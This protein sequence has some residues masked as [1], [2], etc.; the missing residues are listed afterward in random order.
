M[1]KT[2]SNRHEV[3]RF[4]RFNRK[5]Y[6]LF[7]SIGREVLIGTL[8][9]TTLTFAKAEGIST[10]PIRH[11]S[12]QG[13]SNKEVLLDEVS[14]TGSRVPMTALQSARIVSVITR[15]DIARANAES[16]NDLLKIAT[17]V[18][19][20]QRG[21]FGVQT[22]ISIDG[23]TFDQITILL[24]GVNISNPQ[25]GHLAA[26][27]PV[28]LKDIERIEV[29]EGASARV[30]GCSAFS[31]AI[32]IITRSD[33]ESNVR[34]GAE[35]GLFGSFGTSAGFNLA[36]GA[37]RNSISGGYQQSDG[38]TDNSDFKRRR[39][40]Y[41]GAYN[42][43][44]FDLQWQAGLSSQ[45]YGANTFYS[46]KFNNQYEENRRYL[47]SITADIKLLNGNKLHILPTLYWNRNNDHYQL[48]RG[49]DFGENYHR[50]DVLG[51]GINAHLTW[52]LGKTA[53][54]A[55]IRRESIL[56]TSLGEPM[57]SADY[58][59]VDGTDR[60]YDHK[61]HRTNTSIYLEHDILLHQFTISAGVL[62]NRNTGLDNDFRFYPGVDISYRPSDNWKIYASW[63]KALRMPT[64]TDLY[65]NNSAQVGTVYLKPERNS[66]L[67][68]GI[69]YRNHGIEAVAAVFY[70]R[71]RNMIDWVYATSTA[72]KYQAMNIGKLDNEGISTDLT[73][74]I[75][76]IT[77]NSHFFI[78]QI[79][80]GYNYLHQTHK[81]DQEIFKS[82]YALEYLKHK[83]TA[84]IDHQIWSNLSASW[85]LR[86]QERMNGYSPYTKIDCKIM[87]KMP[88]YD[89]YVQADN[90]TNHHYYDL[91]AIKQPGI[92]IM[93]GGNIK[94]KL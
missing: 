11:D 85:S 26:D 82:L 58:K 50:T 19:V 49:T 24:N 78:S 7:A 79:K 41:Q 90:L 25:T 76:E 56:S 31:G 72:T 75:P 33:N 77:G 64:Y 38:G 39:G 32:N 13:N 1:Y 81:T 52:D 74:C 30:F 16:I 93:A 22:D 3:L 23:G 12:I 29:L 35:G 15:D 47:T 89:L 55:E 62:A 9:V 6:S 10:M 45:D 94:F 69:R 43:N 80:L 27:F 70:S 53:L 65:T 14:V 91:T 17:G 5:G 59:K 73:F 20:R 21:S 8:S 57:D 46:A 37:W 54:G 84:E 2:N 71:G 66:V 44:H 88:T 87:W 92:W 28:D 48:K 42:S 60:F 67:K 40:F 86:W 68:T 61:A 51:G 36:N 63:N 4:K 83:F 18:D 34:V